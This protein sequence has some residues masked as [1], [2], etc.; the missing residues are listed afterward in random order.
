M[1]RDSPVESRAASMAS[2]VR[3][4]R[5]VRAA[6]IAAILAAL[7]VLPGCLHDDGEGPDP[8]VFT[9]PSEPV[10]LWGPLPAFSFTPQEPD[11]GDAVSFD[12]SLSDIGPGHTIASYEWSF[13]D[14][15][16][17]GPAAIA[18]ATRTYASDGA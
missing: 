6:T 9:G 7:A 12:A 1:T 8:L 3:I 17:A 10:P 2:P 4:G 13:G 16:T 15:G 14:G 5:T 11:A 18:T